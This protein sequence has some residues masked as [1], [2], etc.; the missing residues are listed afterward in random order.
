MHNQFLNTESGK[1]KKKKLNGRVVAHQSSKLHSKLG[2]D[3]WFVIFLQPMII[4][5]MLMPVMWKVFPK[6]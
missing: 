6:F 1:Y 4:L 2:K 3:V 5:C